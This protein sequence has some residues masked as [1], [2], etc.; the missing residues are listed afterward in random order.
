[1]VLEASGLSSM[2]ELDEFLK[3][4]AFKRLDPLIEPEQVEAKREVAIGVSKEILTLLFG[5][6]NAVRTSV[7]PVCGR[8][9]YWAMVADK[10]V[11]Y[12]LSPESGREDLQEIVHAA[13]EAEVHESFEKFIYA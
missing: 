8:A 3:N 6:Q 7:R 4:H 11:E 5:L 12:I 2:Q 13:R 1:M 10:V 9:L